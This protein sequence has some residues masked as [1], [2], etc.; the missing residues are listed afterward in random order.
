[1]STTELKQL[2]Q[3]AAELEQQAAEVQRQI[4]EPHLRR[5]ALKVERARVRQQLAAARQAA[6]KAEAEQRVVDIVRAHGGLRSTLEKDL[7]RVQAKLDEAGAAITT[8]NERY[9]QLLSLE[10]EA[11]DLAVDYGLDRATPPRV[12]PPAEALK[13]ARP[14]TDVRL[15]TLDDEVRLRRVH[16]KERER[17]RTR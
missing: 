3:E 10:M 6:A 4:A 17:A 2:E 11:R 16:A 15:F 14:Q 1:M 7:E 12:V 8:A 9:R 5:Q 13:T